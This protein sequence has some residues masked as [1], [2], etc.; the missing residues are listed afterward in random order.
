M[1]FD[2][3]VQSSDD[4]DTSLLSLS[5][6]DECAELSFIL[7]ERDTSRHSALDTSRVTVNTHNS[8][9]NIT[10][11]DEDDDDDD[12]EALHQSFQL[13][14][15]DSFSSPQAEIHFIMAV[16]STPTLVPDECCGSSKLRLRPR[17]D[18][19]LLDKMTEGL[20]DSLCFNGDSPS[21]MWHGYHMAVES[22]ILE[23]LS[24]INPPNSAEMEQIWSLPCY[25]GLAAL[26]A[27]PRRQTLHQRAVKVRRLRHERGMCS[28]S[29][30]SVLPRSARSIDPPRLS[31]RADFES[32]IGFG[33]DPILA[34]EETLLGYDSDPEEF[35][36]SRDLEHPLMGVGPVERQVSKTNFSK[37]SIYNVVQESFNLTWSLTWHPGKHHKHLNPV[38]VQAWLE[39]GN[40]LQSNSVMLEPCLMWRES[41]QPGLASQRKLNRS[42]KKPF[43]IRL[44]T[45]CR[46]RPAPAELNRTMYP[47]ARS[48]R[49]LVLLTSDKQEFLLEASSE[50]ERDETLLRWKQTVARFA[51]LAVMEDVRT[52]HTEFFMP[53]ITSNMLVPDYFEVEG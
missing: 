24:Y 8:I 43:S 23:L 9:L 12:D 52:I 29:P 17:S 25:S 1:L 7:S 35:S 53:A 5:S 4:H 42:T 46:M 10:E 16:P 18:S 38:C 48:S 6:P 47:M 39:R 21:S 15:D 45:L 13:D 44:L 28:T 3:E 11:E 30:V 19:S 41:Y 34:A 36:F 31:S 40:L 20:A 50:K 27:R 37:T 22:E 49:C 51:M 32:K 33:M 14:D 26:P 2:V